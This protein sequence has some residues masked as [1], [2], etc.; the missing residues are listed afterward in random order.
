MT[1]KNVSL[2]PPTASIA[3]ERT[4]REAL[5]LMV[6]KGMNHLPVCSPEG[7]YLGTVGTDAI[8]QR[9]LPCGFSSLRFVG[10]AEH[11]LREHLH[12]LENVKVSEFV[13]KNVVTLDEDC[14]VLE[15]ANLLA[16]N[17]LPLPVVDR[18]G[19]LLGMVSKRALLAH[20]LQRP[21]S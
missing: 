4:I 20:L 11:L 9:L 17:S 10:D 21:E 7:K 18:A 19:K 13:R 8:L 5:E 16:Q 6:E 3:P 1:I 2:T 12:R 14:T 15:A